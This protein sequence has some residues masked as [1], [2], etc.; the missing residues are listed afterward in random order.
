MVS[1]TMSLVNEV[2]MMILGGALMLEDRQ[3][4]EVQT[5]E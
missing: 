4:D 1:S 2:A 3:I 5:A